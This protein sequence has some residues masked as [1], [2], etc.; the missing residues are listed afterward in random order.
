MDLVYVCFL[1]VH[2]AFQALPKPRI[3][4]L[5]KFLKFKIILSIIFVLLTVQ[6]NSMLFYATIQRALGQETKTFV[7]E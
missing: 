3:I 4:S 2:N 1:H 5:L 6:Q 7:L